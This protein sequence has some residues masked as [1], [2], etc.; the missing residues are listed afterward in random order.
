[1]FTIMQMYVNVNIQVFNINFKTKK[2][3]LNLININSYDLSK[4]GDRIKYERELITNKNGKSLTQEDLAKKLNRESRQTIAKWEN[5]KASPSWEDMVNMCNLFECD[6]DY[7]SGKIPCKTRENT[8][9]KNALKLEENTINR[10]KKN[11]PFRQ[12]IEYISKGL[13][14]YD[15]DNNIEKLFNSIEKYIQTPDTESKQSAIAMYE[16]QDSLSKLRM[17]IQHQEKD[18]HKR[19]F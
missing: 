10:I 12:L 9:I 11:L 8:D 3:V 13:I 15:S 6:M 7:L 4:V 5:G 14:P 16:I 18:I 1:M 17:N 2:G 19:L